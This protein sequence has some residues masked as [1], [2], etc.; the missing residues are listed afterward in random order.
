[1]KDKPRYFKLMK[2]TIV[3]RM[4]VRCADCPMNHGGRECRAMPASVTGF[5]RPIPTTGPAFPVLCPLPAWPGTG[6]KKQRGSC[7][8]SLQSPVDIQAARCAAIR[9]EY[10]D[11]T[12]FM[13]ARGYPVSTA[14]FAMQ[15]RIRGPKSQRIVEDVK[16]TFGL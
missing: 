9:S 13:K 1:M 7:N 11:L 12:N 3:A 8:E 14:W 2:S 4:I 10:G 6:A 5:D 15:G 16:A